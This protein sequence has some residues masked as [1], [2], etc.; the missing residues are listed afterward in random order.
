MNKSLAS[1]AMLVL[2]SNVTA[3]TIGSRLDRLND[4][5]SRA[6]LARQERALQE[7]MLRGGAVTLPTVVS[8]SGR[9][10]NL[11][12]RLQLNPTSQRNFAVGESVGGGYAIVAIRPQ[13]VLVGRPAGKGG[14]V[15]VLP[16]AF[17]QPETSGKQGP[18]ASPALQPAVPALPA[19]L[20]APFPAP[21]PR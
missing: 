12:A 16:L 7:E 13:E 6:E 4:L 17:A 19:P 18:S 10:H 8:I 2:A 20:A 21:A 5:K 9:S 15:V 3:D 1:L 14:D 11:V